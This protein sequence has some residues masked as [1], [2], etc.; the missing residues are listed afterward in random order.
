MSAPKIGFDLKKIRLSL[1]VILPVRK[2]RNPHK[3]IRR[4]QTIVASVKELGLI[5]PLMVFPQKNKSGHYLLMDGHLRYYALK[6]LGIGEADCIICHQDESFT[7]NAR[8]NRLSPIQE[9]GMI[10]KAIKNGV[11][12]ERIAT[13]LNLK[14]DRVHDTINLLNGIHAEAIEIIKDKQICQSAIRVLKKVIPLRQIEMAELMVTANNFSRGYAHAL[15]MGTPADQ[16]TTPDK[17]KQVKGLSVE[18]I[19]RMEQEMQSAE[20]DFK[21]VEQSY[22]ENVFNLTLAGAYV[23]K[24]LLNAKVIRFLSSKY[25]DIFS[26]FEDVAATEML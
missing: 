3:T 23:K 21:A 16:L 7:Y 13:A 8:I 17:P 22:G 10:M 4:Y 12:P 15:L 1:D 9:H 19:G 18:D 2:I 5:E 14:V 20:H 26:V 25:T 24:L 11:T 6:E